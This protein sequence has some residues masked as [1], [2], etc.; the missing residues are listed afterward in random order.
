MKKYRRQSFI[1]RST[2]SEAT[3]SCD[4]EERGGIPGLHADLSLRLCARGR[5]APHTGP[6]VYWQ[7]IGALNAHQNPS[8]RGYTFI[9]T[10]MG[11]NS[12]VLY[13]KWVFI[14]TYTRVQNAFSYRKSH[15]KTKS[16]DEPIYWLVLSVYPEPNIHFLF[17][18]ELHCCPK[19]QWVTLL[20]W[21]TCSFIIMDTHT[22]AHTHT[23]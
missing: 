1:P 13:I 5:A 18:W 7:H 22:H 4:E 3:M 10:E 21:L 6:V 8:E 17:F 16:K 20:Y 9:F 15:E 2:S 14:C 12:P 23:L 11:A 19:H